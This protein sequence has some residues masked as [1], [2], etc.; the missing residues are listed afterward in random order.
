MH[1]EAYLNC[2]DFVEKHVRPRHGDAPL[3]VL[4]VGA[5]AIREMPN[6]LRPLFPPPWRYRGLDLEPGTNIDIVAKPYV[7]PLPG[8]SND[9]VVSSSCF[10]HVAHFWRLFDEMVRV[11][12]VGGLIWIDA[13]S[14]GPVHWGA[15]YWR[16]LP[17]CWAALA[18]W[19]PYVTLLESRLGGSETWQDNVGVFQRVKL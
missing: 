4:D 1:P 19:N 14:A 10:E 17:G 9:V 13:P 15:D 3:E 16:F 6:C 7:F 18:E 8:L 2:R 5:Q 11:T 12:R